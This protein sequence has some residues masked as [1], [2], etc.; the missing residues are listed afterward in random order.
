MLTIFR[1]CMIVYSASTI[2]SDVCKDDEQNRRNEQH[3]FVLNEK[4]LCDQKRRSDIEKKQGLKAVVV[5]FVSVP[6]RIGPDAQRKTDH[7]RFEQQ[8]MDDVDPEQGERC[9]K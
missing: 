2:I 4:L 7:C 5:L 3:G 9:K 6:K 1:M 8:I